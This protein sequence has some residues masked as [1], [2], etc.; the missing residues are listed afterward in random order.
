[1]SFIVEVPIINPVALQIGYVAIRWY[2]LAYIFGLISALLFLKK[3]NQKYHLM[4]AKAEESWINWAILGII[5]GGRLGYVIFYNFSFYLLHPLDILKIWQGG[6]SFH[7]GLIGSIIAMY[8]FCNKYQ[9]NFLKLCDC[10]AI[11]SPIGIFFGRIANFINLEL[12]GRVTNSESYGFIF[13]A[14]DNQKRHPSQLYEAILEGIIPFLILYILSRNSKIISKLG[15]LSGM[16]LILYGSA[17]IFVENFREPDSH[18]G[19]IANQMT[20]GQILSL[21][22]VLIGLFLIIYNR[23]I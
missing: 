12:Y 23:K 7:G 2:S 4:T 3:F 20:M 15:L 13:T 19:F 1:M 14:I 8:F 9:V 16:F 18:I 21:P 6:M 11:I 5:I 10:I 22:I 17:R